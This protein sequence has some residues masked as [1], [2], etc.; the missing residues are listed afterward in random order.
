MVD[1][2]PLSDVLLVNLKMLTLSELNFLI[3]KVRGTTLMSCGI[4]GN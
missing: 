1:G 4:A 3:G 2:M